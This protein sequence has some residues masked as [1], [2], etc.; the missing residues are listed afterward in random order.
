MRYARR[1]I[2]AEKDDLVRN[3]LM[4]A[5]GGV[6]KS[7]DSGRRKEKEE[8]AVR[9]RKEKDDFARNRL[10]KAN[11]GVSKSVDTGRR[12]EKEEEAVRLRA[13][14][15]ELARERLVKAK[16][17]KVKKN[18]FGFAGGKDDESPSRS[19]IERIRKEKEAEIARQQ[20]ANDNAA[21]E[22]SVKP[23]P[24]CEVTGS[25]ATM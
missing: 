24:R 7:V 18:K 14:M 8:E 10:M 16:G 13:E 11:G 5:K 9:L 6:S 22:K 4:K 21:R 1:R 19:R 23:K 3:R 2:R 20:A 12:K 25:E 15:D 17:G